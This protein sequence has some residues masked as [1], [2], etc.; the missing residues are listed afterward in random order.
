M[1]FEKLYN[2]NLPKLFRIT[3]SEY[4]KAF[5]FLHIKIFTNQW[6][7]NIKKNRPFT[8]AVS[9]SVYT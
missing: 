8:T 3:I 6:A 7:K 9:E 1:L 4:N 2:L 5:S